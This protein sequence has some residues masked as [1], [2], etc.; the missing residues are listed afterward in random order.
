MSGDPMATADTLKSGADAAAANVR[1]LYITFL[2]AGVYAA[3]VVGATTD[4]Q[5]FSVSPV[6][7]PILDVDL[8]IVAFYTV[9]PWLLLLLHFNLM[10]QL[11]LLSR[12]LHLLDEAIRE[13]RDPEAARRLRITLFGFPFSHLLIGEP[14]GPVIRA[15]MAMVV[16]LTLIVLPLLLLVWAQIRFLP[17]HDPLLTWTQRLAILLDLATLWTF[18]PRILTPPGEPISWLRHL[19]AGGRG[20][21]A[22]VATAAAAV[23][24]SVLTA[25]IPAEAIERWVAALTFD[26]EYDPQSGVAPLWATRRLFDGPSAPFHRNLRLPERVLAA[27]PPDPRV[28]DILYGRDSEE[29][30]T[31]IRQT[32]GLDL[33]LR[34]LRFADL[35]GVVL[36]NADLRGADLGGADLRG[37][38]LFEVD[39]RPADVSF[40]GRCPHRGAPLTDL[41][42]RQWNVWVETGLQAPPTGAARFCPTRVRAARL[43][44][45]QVSG[46]RMALVEISDVQARDLS[47]NLVDLVGARVQNGVRLTQIDAS[48]VRLSHATLRDV[49]LSSGTEPQGTQAS[50]LVGLDLDGAH[51]EDVRFVRARLWNPRL[52]G[53]RLVR[54]HFE[55]TTMTDARFDGAELGAVAFLGASFADA[56]DFT[57]ATLRDVTFDRANLAGV[58]LDRARFLGRTSFAGSTLTAADLSGASLAGASFEGAAYSGARFVGADLRRANFAGGSE[59]AIVADFERADLRS[60]TLSGRLRVASFK[61][62]DLRGARFDGASTLQLANF[63]RARVGGLGLELDDDY[64]RAIDVAQLDASAMDDAEGRAPAADPRGTASVDRRGARPASLREGAPGIIDADARPRAFVEMLGDVVLRLG[65]PCA[66]EPA[67]NVMLGL[68]PLSSRHPRGAAARGGAVDGLEFAAEPVAVLEA[69]LAAATR[70]ASCAPQALGQ[71]ARH[72][73]HALSVMRALADTTSVDPGCGKIEGQPAQVARRVSRSRWELRSCADLAQPAPTLWPVA[74]LLR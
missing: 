8:P 18:W 27:R 63:R 10:L 74:S 54:V 71:R 29:R 60:A 50:R 66:E 61:D 48:D 7:L 64:E 36:P 53:A 57:R 11:L 43:D 5:L 20:G 39:M 14:I 12:R 58:R 38:R 46:A 34:D 68:L 47:L 72:W 25:T 16:W 13:L 17:Y 21:I 30:V 73:E 40:G 65:Y 42:Q 51:L 45:L 52:S 1:N 19:T 67:R 24:L 56:P 3:I 26:D 32:P 28:V 49:V 15:L 69:K 23:W 44:G 6:T 2:L 22:V 59:S 62:A 33:R 41:G 9:V 70:M 4:W 31:A 37:A 35:R 55:S